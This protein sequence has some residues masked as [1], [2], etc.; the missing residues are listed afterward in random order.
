M[1]FS[2]SIMVV[3]PGC[4]TGLIQE[5]LDDSVLVASTILLLPPGTFPED[6][7][8]VVQGA[9]S[10]RVG[11]RHS[12]A[13][14]FFSTRHLEWLRGYLRSSEHVMVVIPQSPYEDLSSA[15]TSLLV[16]LLSG[17]T[18]TVLRPMLEEPGDQP[19]S[20]VN[21][22]VEGVPEKWKFLELNTPLLVQDI[23]STFWSHCPVTVKNFIND[24]DRDL[25]YYFRIYKVEGNDVS[26]E[27]LEPD[28]LPVNLKP[29]DASPE[30]IQHDVEYTVHGACIWLD[31]LPNGGEFL[32]GKKV[33]EIG[34]GINFGAMLVLACHGA[35]VMVADRFLT[36]W[37][38]EYHPIF[39]KLLR[40]NL[41]ERWPTIDPSP[42]DT[43]ISQ[44][45]Y[46]PDVISLYSCSLEKLTVPH[47][48]V[49]LVLSNSV[50]EHL[51]DLNLAFYHL[52]RITK[53][54][55]LG[56]H[57]VDFRD[58]RDFSRPL[59]YL[60]S[61]EREFAREF[62][63]SLGQYGNRYR[64]HEMQEFLERAGFEVKEFRDPDI[65]TAEEY[66]TEFLRRLRKTRKSR[67]RY[68][69]VENLRVL[70][71][72]FVTVKKPSSKD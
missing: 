59:E 52:S 25:Y 69:P 36:P 32:K 41:T 34:P 55:G 26:P 57:M 61:S 22:N 60:L 30:A 37:N 46:P 29:L 49:D 14:R 18:I 58:H 56:I 64:P 4:P 53:P 19:G 38:P 42:L 21:P 43:V 68:C 6:D 71:G 20:N 48:S 51:Y 47:E 27:N 72:R 63:E 24:I 5:L 10:E 66:L 11:F 65:F 1:S 33:L 67:Y 54:G 2:E 62:E 12:P 9:P 8:W 50:F 3:A 45:G 13:R 23:C 39:Y 7:G 16:M 44:G 40:D 15:G 28:A 35:Q 70:T 31:L 17:K